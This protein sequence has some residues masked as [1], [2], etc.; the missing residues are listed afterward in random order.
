M[1][2]SSAT[3][4]SAEE[5]SLPNTYDTWHKKSGR[6]LSL[7]NKSERGPEAFQ[8]ALERDGENVTLALLDKVLAKAQYIND[9]RFYGT[10]LPWLASKALQVE[11][12]FK[13]SKYTILASVH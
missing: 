13:E 9:D 2:S 1:A 4:S 6:L 10:L 11:S 8:H 5:I 7:S 12:L 3:D